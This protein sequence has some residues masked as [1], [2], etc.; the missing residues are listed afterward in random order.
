MPNANSTPAVNYDTNRQVD[1]QTLTLKKADGSVVLDISS[2]LVQFIVYEDLFQGSLSAFL[3]IADQ[4]NLVGTLPIVG[5]ETVSITFKTPFYTD[6]VSLDFI[7]Y[8]IGDRDLPNGPENI[9]VSGFHLCAPEVWFAANND[10]SAGYQGTYSDIISRLVQTT[11]TK[12]ALD[13]EESV[14]IVTYAAPSCSIF[15]SIKFCA[16]RANSSTNSPMFFWETLYGYKFKSMKT[17]YRTDYNKILYISPRNMIDQSDPEKLFNT[18]YD[19]DFPENNDRLKQYSRGAFGATFYSMDLTNKRIAKTVNKYEDVFNAADIK[20]DK[21]P[22]NDPMSKQRQLTEY[23]PY[24]VD[25][26]H[27]SGFNRLATLSMMDNFKLMINIPGDSAMKVG[28]VV[29]L[30]IPSRS[31]LGVDTEKLTSGKWLYRS[32][33]HLITKSTYS[34]TAELTK[35]SFDADPTSM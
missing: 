1:I 13:K 26:S 5:G 22:L 28:D 19:F 27:L 2:V 4:I 17:L 25:G 29:W 34:I 30:E 15:Q 14:G 7:I 16:S 23:M 35:D 21:F 32:A 10:S 8:K 12:K 31:G 20:I 33:K 24:R 11:G 6:T 9:Q 18:L 3:L